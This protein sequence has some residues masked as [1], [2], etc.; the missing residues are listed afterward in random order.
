MTTLT[1]KPITHPALFANT[2][3]TPPLTPTSPTVLKPVAPTPPVVSYPQLRAHHATALRYIIAKL[4]W[5]QANNGYLRG[6]DAWLNHN[7]VIGKLEKELHDV[8]EAQKGLDRFPNCF[9]ATAFP[10]PHGPLS[11]SEYDAKKKAEAEE[12]KALDDKLDAQFPFIKQLFIGPRTKQQARND[13]MMREMMKEGDFD[14]LSVLLPSENMR[15]LMEGQAAKKA[16]GPAGA[17]KKSYEQIRL[18]KEKAKLAALGVEAPKKVTQG[19][20]ASPRPKFGPLT[21]QEYVA[22]LPKFGPVTLQE[23]LLPTQREQRHVILSWLRKP[24]PVF[25]SEAAELMEK[26][27]R[28]ALK[29]L[30]VETKTAKGEQA[31]EAALAVKP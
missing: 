6:E 23:Y 10:K 22:S 25:D 11:K 2:L 24:W 3:L 28:L 20:P 7:K 15:M 19:S 29:K 5:E 4:R 27:G 17:Q 9:A 26:L 13:K 12:A 1:L 16:A 21:Y 14:D 31:K 30:D 8:E 18:E